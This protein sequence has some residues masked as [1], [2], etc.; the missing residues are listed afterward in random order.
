MTKQDTYYQK[1]FEDEKNRAFSEIETIVS[2]GPMICFIKGTQA[3]PKCKFTRKL[4][5]LMQGY[6]FKTFN[7]LENERIR[8]WT[9]F[10]SKWPTYPQV[11]LK[12]EFI[13]GIDVVLEL[14][15][16]G[17]FESMAPLESRP[18]SSVDKFEEYIQLSETLVLIEGSPEQ[19]L[20]L[21][22]KELLTLLSSHGVKFMSLNIKD[23][24]A[25][26]PPELT[27]SP[28]SRT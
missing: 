13:G 15:E 25:V 17:E 23:C 8:Q 27:S 14:F 9:K 18:I 10:Y 11:Y 3:E 4:M 26:S 7:I 2:G 16:D 20:T 21:K 12:G 5:G 19:P 28:F 6:R 22:S 1:W 24:D